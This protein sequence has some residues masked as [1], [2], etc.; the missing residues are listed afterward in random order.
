MGTADRSNVSLPSY[1]VV[2]P[3]LSRRIDELLEELQPYPHLDFIREV[4]VTAVKLAGEDCGRGD[5]KI[6]R[7]ATKE[8]RYAFKLFSDYRHAKKVTIFGSSRTVPDNPEYQT[9]VALS[10]KMAKRGYMVITGA[11]G[12]IMEAGNRGAGREHSFGLNIQLPFE[13]EANPVISG[14]SKL[15]NFRYFF[16]RKLF[17]VKESNAVVLMP[18]GVG[19]QD[20]GFE[21]L[22]LVQTGR[23]D[24]IP[25][26]MLDAPGG[27]YWKSW[28]R[29]FRE[30]AGE[31]LC[32]APGRCF[33]SRH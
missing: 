14:D 15:I 30:D 2:D 3:A 28:Y 8:L 33:L 19:T 25:I 6:L 7:S 10:R 27:T 9:A 20:E 24:P 23:S 1:D 11:G 12:G 17:F 26:V 22:T 16:T 4:L 21:T 31:G 18:G 32:F 13:Q 5:L 29:F